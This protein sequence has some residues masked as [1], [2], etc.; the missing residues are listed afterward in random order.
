MTNIAK[1]AGEVF[2][3]FYSVPSRVNQIQQNL[4]SLTWTSFV[5]Y[6]NLTFVN[7]IAEQ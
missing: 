2:F 3:N 5:N 4:L 6:V 7:S 1:E